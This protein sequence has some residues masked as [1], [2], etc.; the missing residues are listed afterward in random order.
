MAKV[1]LYFRS[2][3]HIQPE[4]AVAEVHEAFAGRGQVLRVRKLVQ[5]A[6]EGAAYALAMGAATS[7]VVGRIFAGQAV[8]AVDGPLAGLVGL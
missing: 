4:Q 3:R 8:A 7:W 5:I 6:V 1:T 2:P